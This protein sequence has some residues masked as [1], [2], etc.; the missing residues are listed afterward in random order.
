MTF[1]DLLERLQSALRNHPDYADLDVDIVID[2]RDSTADDLLFVSGGGLL[3]IEIVPTF[4]GDDDE[5]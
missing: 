4:P 2:D 5:S 1:K 3:A